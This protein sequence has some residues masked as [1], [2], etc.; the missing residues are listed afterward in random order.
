MSL[1]DY[2][3]FVYGAGLLNEPDPVASWQKIGQEQQ[4]MVDWLK[5]RDQVLSE[6]LQCGSENVHQRA[7]FYPLRWTG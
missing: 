5:G 4:K 6:R 3:E 2:R 7:P 1:S